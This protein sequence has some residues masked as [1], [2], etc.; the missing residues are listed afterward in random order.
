M[1]LLLICLLPADKN[2][3]KSH[4]N[5]HNSFDNMIRS[6]ESSIQLYYH[7]RYCCRKEGE[8]PHPKYPTKVNVWAGISKIE[9][10]AFAYLKA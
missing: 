5:L 6:N 3:K 10:Q 9:L 7:R 8:R 4:T 2:S 1:D